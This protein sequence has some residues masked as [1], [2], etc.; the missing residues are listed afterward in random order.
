MDQRT[1]MGPR[2]PKNQSAQNL[3]KPDVCVGPVVMNPTQIE[4]DQTTKDIAI[5]SFFQN[6]KNLMTVQ[7]IQF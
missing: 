6:D 7:C 2:R 4:W 3:C 1:K 5:C